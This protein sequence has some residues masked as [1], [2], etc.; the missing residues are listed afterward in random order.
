MPGGLLWFTDDY[1]PKVGISERT[2]MLV[3]LPPS[4]SCWRP[5]SQSRDRDLVERLQSESGM[6]YHPFPGMG[7]SNT[8]AQTAQRGMGRPAARCPSFVGASRAGFSLPLGV[9]RPDR[10]GRVAKAQAWGPL[11]ATTVG[12][13]DAQE[14]NPRTHYFSLSAQLPPALR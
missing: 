14:E 3:S 8:P 6:S 2:Q 12:E 5:P 13:G 1:V 4:P 11:D 9:W 7:A 10:G